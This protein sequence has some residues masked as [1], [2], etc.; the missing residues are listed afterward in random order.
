MRRLLLGLLLLFAVVFTTVCTASATEMKISAK[1]LERTLRTQLFNGPEGRYYMRG[2]ASSTCYVYADSPHVSFVQ[3]RIVVHVHTKAKLGTGVRGACIG[4]SLTRDADVSMIPNAEGET[5]GFRDARIE[6]L[7]DSRELNFLLVPFLSR[8][9]PQQMKVNAADLMRQLL[10]RSAETTGY[11]LSLSSLKIHSM[12]V[13]G[14]L[15]V[16]DIDAGMNVN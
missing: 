2:D 10:S 9:L 16:V 14:E 15:L 1:A 12:I 7:S 13:Q 8:K 11:A 5:I 4:V 6:Q 3:D